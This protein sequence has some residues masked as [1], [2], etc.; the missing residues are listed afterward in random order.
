MAFDENGGA[1]AIYDIM[2]W[3]PAN[4]GALHI[5][6]IGRFDESAPAGQELSLIEGDIFWNSDSRTVQ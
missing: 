2:N 1:L 4:D 3:Q 5:K 6:T